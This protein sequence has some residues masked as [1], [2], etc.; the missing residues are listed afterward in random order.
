MEYLSLKKEGHIG[1]ITLDRPPV[2]ALNY[3]AYSEI[4]EVFELVAQDP[5]IWCVIFQ[6]QNKLFCAGNDLNELDETAQSGA[7]DTHEIPYGDMVEKGLTSVIKCK[8]PVITCV[9]STAVGAGFCIA[10]YSDIVLAAPEA[11]FGITEVTVGIIG[12]GPEASHSLPPK[13]VRYMA[14][15]GNLLTAQQAKDYNMVMDIVPQDQLLETAMKLA[16][17]IISLPPFTV[18]CME[19]SLNNI[20][21]PAHIADLVAFDGDKTMQ[22]LESEDYK[23]A[24]RAFLEKRPPVYHGR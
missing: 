11:K 24:L 16:K 21:P 2:N 3:Q 8:V 15:T 9:H 6:A 4:F 7:E 13:V 18:K 5:E 12:G 14:L 19:E 22:S 20:Y 23:E 17:R 10:T 1:I